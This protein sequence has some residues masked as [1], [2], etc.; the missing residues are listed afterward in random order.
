MPSRHASRAVAIAASL[1]LGLAAAI[2]PVARPA[3]A[4]DKADLTI[5]TGST[6]ITVRAGQAFTHIFYVKNIGT[7]DAQA[8]VTMAAAMP[9][10]ATVTQ[11]SADGPILWNCTHIQA[12]GWC[13]AR[14]AL[15]G[16]YYPTRIRVD[17]TAPTTPGT[18]QI[19]SV[20]DSAD[21]VDE[22]NENNNVL[23]TTLTVTP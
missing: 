23:H 8:G 14:T 4:A 6:S 13:S 3:E 21:I 16:G 10:S 15:P 5:P 19:T 18:Y 20:A 17:V 1:T 7:A 2:M 11:V 12:V 22:S 9:L